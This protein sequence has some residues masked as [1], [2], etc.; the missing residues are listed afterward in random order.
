MGLCLKNQF[1][2]S[3][4]QGADI[5]DNNWVVIDWQND[6]DRSVAEWYAYLSQISNM[7]NVG[8]FLFEPG[9]SSGLVKLPPQNLITAINQMMKELNALIIV[10]EVT[11]GIGRTGKWFGYMHYNLV[12]DIIAAGKGLGN[13]YPVSAVIMKRHVV[14]KIFC[15]PFCYAQS[16]QNDPLGAAIAYKVLEVIEREHL[17]ERSLEN[18][19]YLRQCYIEL[20][21]E[22][23]CIDEVRGIG[24]MNCIEFKDYMDEAMMKRIDKLLCEEGFL[25]AVKPLHRVLRTYT[26]F[27]LTKEM[28]DAY[29]TTLSE[30]LNTCCAL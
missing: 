16:H 30:V 17:I 5:S 20:Q 24:M 25:V 9:N 7:T 1:F 28:I 29:C 27:T 11:T 12:P 4:G 23:Q 26:P 2:T 3:Y 21:K 10:D 22:H 6:N 13:G 15:N 14:E 19:A 18:G 8:Y